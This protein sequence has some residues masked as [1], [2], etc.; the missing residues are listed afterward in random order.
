MQSIDSWTAPQKTQVTENNENYGFTISMQGIA[1]RELSYV[2]VIDSSVL[3][4]FSVKASGEGMT[5]ELIRS[6]SLETAN[7]V[8]VYNTDK[9]RY[10]LFVLPYNNTTVGIKEIVY[11]EVPIADYS[12]SSE[13]ESANIGANMFDGDFST[14]WTTLN[15]GETAMFDLGATKDIDGIAAGF[16]KS[17]TRR[18]SFDILT[19]ADGTNWATAGSFQSELSP[20]DY[21]VFKFRANCRYIK[22]VGK[23]NTA[24]VNSNVLEFRAVRMKE[25]FR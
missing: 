6:D 10:K 11:D 1:D 8:K 5:A 2:P 9:S 14:R 15:T 4:Q 16:W 19:S 3:P 22:F 17:D 20:E 21:Q 25:E 23:G 12:V 13:P 18:Y 7:L 24:N